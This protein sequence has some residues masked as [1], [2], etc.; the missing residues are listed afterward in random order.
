METFATPV[1]WTLTWFDRDNELLVGELSAPHLTEALVRAALRVP[2]QVPLAGEFPV[3]EET[4]SAVAR[5][6]GHHIE[7]ERYHYFVGAVA[8]S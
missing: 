1:E 5:L 2:D 4:A 6:W 3:T 8:K 7:L